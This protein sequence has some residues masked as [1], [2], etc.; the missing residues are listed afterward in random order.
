MTGFWN[1]ERA[2][3]EAGLTLTEVADRAGFTA[4]DVERLGFSWLPSAILDRLA[5]VLGLS[6]GQRGDSHAEPIP[7]RPATP[8]ASEPTSGSFRRGSPVTSSR[9]RSDGRSTESSELWLRLTTSF[10]HAGCASAPEK[11]TESPSRDGW[12]LPT[13]TRA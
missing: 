1:L 5:D 12:S 11:A 6:K 4:S 2:L 9:K 8:R 3:D 13:G 7:E 10:V